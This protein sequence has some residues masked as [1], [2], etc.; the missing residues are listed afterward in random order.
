MPEQHGHT[1]K[2]A[3]VFLMHYRYI[4]V[5]SDNLIRSDI[6][7]MNNSYANLDLNKHAC[8]SSRKNE[9]EADLLL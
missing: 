9:P 5:N 1:Q 4:V 8:G 7:S 6:F 3:G 2:L